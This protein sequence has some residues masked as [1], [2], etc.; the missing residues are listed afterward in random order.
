MF[1]NTSMFNKWHESK[2]NE[3]DTCLSNESQDDNNDKYNFIGFDALIISIN[4]IKDSLGNLM[5]YNSN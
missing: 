2:T 3:Y 1:G 5:T 4:S